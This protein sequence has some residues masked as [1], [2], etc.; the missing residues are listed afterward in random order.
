MLR[1]ALLS[2]AYWPEVRRGTERFAHELVH[3]LVAR[4]HRARLITS[5]PGPRSLREEDGVEVV[6]TRR[7]P[8]R[9]LR[10]LGLEHH[11]T[12]VPLTLR[13]LGRGD[14]DVAHALYH[15]DALAA[16]RWSARNGRP[17]VFSFMGIPLE[18]TLEHRRLTRRIL[19]RA[20]ERADAFVVLSNTAAERFRALAGAEPRV[21]APGVD[22]ATFSPAGDRAPEP[23]I[24]CAAD[25]GE[26]RKRVPL[27]V[28]AFRELRRERPDARL[29]LSRPRDPDAV[30]ALE[31]IPGVELRDVDDSAALVA[32]YRGAWVSA[33]PSYSEA[34][35]LVL[36]ESMACGT[37]VV[38]SDRDA[39]PE[40]ID[41]PE[42]GSTFSG[43]DPAAL[44]AAL[45]ATLERATDPATAI[46]CRRRAE[47]FSTDRCVERYEA[48]YRELLE[49]A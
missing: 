30:A 46:A 38:G 27:L 11:L 7:P 17:H 32:A 33:L 5:H 8:E 41:S 9:P 10:A 14:D 31:G 6:R 25:A 42:I 21:I 28:E 47:E 37:P 40:V 22:V 18:H 35:G 44:A 48:L 43:A 26:P 39:I 12:H 19:L 34:F 23:T 15:A 13:E 16:A 49:R 45:L 3:G 29:V 1:V 2:P 4:G 20:I 24:F 36:V